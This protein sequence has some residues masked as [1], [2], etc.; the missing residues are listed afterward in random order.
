MQAICSQ[1]KRFREKELTATCTTDQDT[2]GQRCHLWHRTLTRCPPPFLQDKY[3]VYQTSC[4]QDMSPKWDLINK[5]KSGFPNHQC[6]LVSCAPVRHRACLGVP[7]SAWAAHEL[8]LF[9]WLVGIKFDEMFGFTFFFFLI[10]GEQFKVLTI[11]SPA[12]NTA[13]STALSTIL[14]S[15]GEMLDLGER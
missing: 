4:I 15:E 7:H 10:L 14:Q 2:Q 6:G 3:K 13:S 9:N 1:R 8:W 11:G 12:L 5:P